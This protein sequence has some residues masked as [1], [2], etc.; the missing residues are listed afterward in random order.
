MKQILGIPVPDSVVRI[1]VRAN[2][3][4]RAGRPRV[5][6]SGEA[7]EDLEQQEIIDGLSADR[8]FWV[9]ANSLI[10][11]GRIGPKEHSLNS[12]SLRITCSFSYQDGNNA[13]LDPATG[14]TTYAFPEPWEFVRGTAGR[15]EHDVMVCLVERLSELVT[16]THRTVADLVDK[17]HKASAEHSRNILEQNKML[18]ELVCKVLKEVS[19]QAR[20]TTIVAAQESSKVM[21]S[22]VEPLR[23]QLNIIDRHSSNET[24]RAN[25]STDAVIRSLNLEASGAKDPRG[26][27]EKLLDTM[28]RGWRFI[29]TVTG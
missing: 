2:G 3:S 23:A 12:I 7:A 24:E 26:E 4:K 20:A 6:Y 11:G 13:V 14:Q 9:W 8:D 16:E 17:T 18:P 19:D 22:M 29:K 21:A 15:T 28:E 5:I 27:E 1:Q 25:K 10:Q